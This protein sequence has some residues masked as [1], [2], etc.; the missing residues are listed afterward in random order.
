MIS[1][2]RSQIG[3]LDLDDLDLV[4]PGSGQTSIWSMTSIWG[5]SDLDD[6][7]LVDLQ[8]IWS[9][10]MILRDTRRSRGS[11]YA[12][13]CVQMEREHVITCVFLTHACTS[14]L[15]ICTWCINSRTSLYLSLPTHYL[16]KGVISGYTLQIPVYI[17]I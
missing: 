7:D 3:V 12:P 11:P 6:L 16:L 13:R 15:L 4:D 5:R 2:S 17:G 10:K 9:N 1:G 14:D 8:S